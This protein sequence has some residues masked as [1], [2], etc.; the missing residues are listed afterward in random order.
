VLFARKRASRGAVACRCIPWPNMGCGASVGERKQAFKGNAVVPAEVISAPIPSVEEAY[1]TGQ[2]DSCASNQPPAPTEEDDEDDDDDA[3]ESDSS[4]SDPNLPQE[5]QWA[6]QARRQERQNKRQRRAAREARKAAAA[7]TDNNAP[8]LDVSYSIGHRIGRG[9]FASV[10]TCTHLQSQGVRALKT[11]DKKKTGSDERIREEIAI[12]KITNHPHIAKVFDIFEDTKCVHIVMELCT[13]GELFEHLSTRQDQGLDEITAMRVIGHLASAMAYLHSIQ[14]AHRDLKPENLLFAKKDEEI[15]Q[16][17]LKVI[18]FG[19][20]K[21]FEPGGFMQTMA[22]TAQYMAPEVAD[23]RYT[24]ACDIWSFGVILYVV[25]C[26]VP[27][28][29][30]ASDDD[31]LESARGCKYE[32][33]ASVWATRPDA[34][35]DL[36]RRMLCVDASARLS[37]PQVLEHAWLR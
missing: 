37:A 13:G 5:M 11:I 30:G 2:A 15:S 6:K 24:Q 34:A 4:G 17:T 3:A 33:D 9:C 25:L 26:G 35:K 16:G 20:A 14:V 8:A 31:I 1:T 29:C 12:V 10:S 7:G 28:F 18:D 32:F 27:P 19:L 21:R 23:R 36:V 22:C